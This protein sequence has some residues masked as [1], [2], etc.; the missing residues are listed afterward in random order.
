MILREEK[1]MKQ[2]CDEMGIEWIEGKHEPM[3]N[4]VPC[5]ELDME[6]LAQ[7]HVF[8]VPEEQAENIPVVTKEQMQHLQKKYGK[9][10]VSES[11]KVNHLKGDETH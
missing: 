6:Q 7:N 10:L 4:G 2:L 1:L 9:Y 8:I 5:G 3:I 11:R